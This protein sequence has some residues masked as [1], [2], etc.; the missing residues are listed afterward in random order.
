MTTDLSTTYAP[1]STVAVRFNHPGLVK[2]YAESHPGWEQSVAD[3]VT[4][5]T[6]ADVEV[7]G[8]GLEF[9]GDLVSFYDV[10]VKV[11]SQTAM[12]QPQ[13]L[14]T[15]AQ[16]GPVAW[17]SLAV[18]VNAIA[19]AI[20]APIVARYLAGAVTSANDPNGSW[21]KLAGASRI[22]AWAAL[23]GAIAALVVAFRWSGRRV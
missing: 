4:R 2:S 21:T 5:Q 22:G 8:S 9:S 1:G 3:Y 7:I 19:F 11:K 6:G 20:A 12:A 17:I 23:A 10:V 18:I 13:D 16:L 15:P 14:V